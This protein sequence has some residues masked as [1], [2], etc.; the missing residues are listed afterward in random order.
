[1]TRLSDDVR[2]ITLALAVKQASQVI[3]EKMRMWRVRMVYQS[4]AGRL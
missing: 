3:A 1:M 2:V 4:M